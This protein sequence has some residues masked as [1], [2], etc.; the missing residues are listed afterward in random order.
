MEE[1]RLIRRRELLKLVP[2]GYTRIFEM[3]RE[4]RF[5]RRLLIA[6]KA[7]A[8]RL[9]EVRAWIDSRPSV[10]GARGVHP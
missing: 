6:D 9:S 10:E 5:P 3:E 8:W 7:V 1:D 2:L 4:G